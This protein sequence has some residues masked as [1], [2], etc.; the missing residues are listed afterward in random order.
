MT[1]AKYCKDKKFTLEQYQTLE[2]NI[3]AITQAIIDQIPDSKKNHGMYY[4]ITELLPYNTN[5]ELK[6]YYIQSFKSQGIEFFD[7]STL[8]RY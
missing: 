3:K 7:N 8:W 2:N 6:P 4:P 5:T 1:L